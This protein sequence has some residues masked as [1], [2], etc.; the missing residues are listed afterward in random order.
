MVQ[1]DFTA[2]LLRLVHE[3]GVLS[4]RTDRKPIGANSNGLKINAVDETS[5][6]D[7]SRWGGVRAYWTAEA[8]SLTATK[9]T[10]RQMELSLQKLTGLYYATDEL[11]MDTVALGAFA[12]EANDAND[13][14]AD[15]DPGQIH[16]VTGRPR[17]PGPGSTPALF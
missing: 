5:R 12:G 16:W 13:G 17:P 1:T 15:A 4:Q 6:V 7:G 2:E 3:T 8:A 14:V 9:P 11:L 10:Y